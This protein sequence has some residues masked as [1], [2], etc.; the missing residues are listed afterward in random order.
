MFQKTVKI[1]N[2]GLPRWVLD[3]HDVCGGNMKPRKQ[4]GMML[5]KFSKPISENRCGVN[6]QRKELH[7]YV[8]GW[9]MTT[10]KFKCLDQKL[11]RLSSVWFINELAI[12]IKKIQKG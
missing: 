1:E 6:A 2:L 10:M 7:G 4:A 11:L 8:G 9:L 12:T 3:V 5:Q